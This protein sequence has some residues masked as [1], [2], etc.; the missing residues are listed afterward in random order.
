[1][2]RALTLLLTCLLLP[3]TTMAA[4]KKDWHRVDAW[5][6]EYDGH[7]RKYTK[8]Y[9]G[10]YF[11]WRWFKAQAIAESGLDP[12]ARSQAGALGLMQIMP[13]TYEEI[14]RDNPHF[15]TLDDPRWNVAAGIYY[16]RVLYRKWQTPPPGTERLY[17][18]FGSYNA[19]YGRLRKATQLAGESAER[20]SEVAPY[21]PSQTRHYVERIRTLMNPVLTED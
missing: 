9:F 3:V 5:P 2:P 6:D 7:F 16:N 19:G 1:M 12:D 4:G 13:A 14:T 18:A 20:W 15:V 17:F 11:D 8:R 21:V 10:P